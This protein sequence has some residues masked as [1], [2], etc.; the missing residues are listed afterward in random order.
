MK[1]SFLVCKLVAPTQIRAL[2]LGPLNKDEKHPFL[3]I[4]DQVKIE[5]LRIE[6]VTPITGGWAYD[7][8]SYNELE[9]G[10]QYD[11]VLEGFTRVSLDVSNAIYFPDFDKK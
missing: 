8:R 1:D 11:I 5:T 7:L 2:L 9:L 4:N 6:K 3:L 10:H